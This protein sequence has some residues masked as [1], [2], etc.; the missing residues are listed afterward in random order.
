VEV[1]SRKR[2]GHSWEKI[3]DKKEQEKFRCNGVCNKQGD[4]KGTVQKV[5]VLEKDCYVNN[6][7][8]GLKDWGFFNYCQTAIEVDR[9]NGFLVKIQK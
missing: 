6:Y 4:C 2:R 9:K 5:Q 3:M 7:K 8:D 1:F